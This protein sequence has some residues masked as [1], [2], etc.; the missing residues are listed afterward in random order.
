M[1]KK[2][3]MYYMAYAHDCKHIYHVVKTTNYNTIYKV[4]NCKKSIKTS[5]NTATLCS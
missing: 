1:K 4:R 5:N 2:I 3:T